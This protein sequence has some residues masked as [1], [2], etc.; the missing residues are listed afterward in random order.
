LKFSS[1]SL[2]FGQFLASSATLLARKVWREVKQMGVPAKI[3]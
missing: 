2:S 1:F 3:K